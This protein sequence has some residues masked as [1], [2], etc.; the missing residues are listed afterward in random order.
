MRYS[1]DGQQVTLTLQEYGALK[2]EA[3]TA[4]DRAQ[5]YVAEA[6]RERR[7]AED[8]LADALAKEPLIRRNDD[9]VN[10]LN[11]REDAAMQIV[12]MAENFM[13]EVYH[14][15]GGVSR[16]NRSDLEL[17]VKKLREGR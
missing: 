5:V 6:D 15:Q 12:R 9:M 4:I 1:E 13:Q 8:V 3:Q 16:T 10:A 7:V 2:A 14:V 17:R 11:L